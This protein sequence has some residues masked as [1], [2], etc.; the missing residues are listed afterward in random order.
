VLGESL[1]PLPVGD[2][3]YVWNGSNVVFIKGRFTFWLSGGFDL[4]AGDFTIDNE[5]KEKF[6]KEIAAAV[7]AN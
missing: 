5:F 4:R 1:I 2:K 6:A 7:D 3:G